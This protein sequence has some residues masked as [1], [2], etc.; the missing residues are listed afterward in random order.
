MDEVLQVALDRMPVPRVVD[1]EGATSP[2][3]SVE[4]ESAPSISTH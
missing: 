1:D 3:I 2:E 4:K